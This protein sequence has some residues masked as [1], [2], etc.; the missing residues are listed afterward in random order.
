MNAGHNPPILVT[1]GGK[2]TTEL[3]KHGLALGVIEDIKLEQHTVQLPLGSVLVLYTDGVTDAMNDE[4]AWFGEE[5]LLSLVQQHHDLP[6]REII[7]RISEALHT[8]VGGQEAF[9]DATII[10]VRSVG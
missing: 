8:F 1:D 10:V 6:A 9:D 5:R 2:T 7:Q 4:G 3:D